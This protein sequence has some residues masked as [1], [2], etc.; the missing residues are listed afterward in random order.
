[1]LQIKIVCARIKINLPISGRWAVFWYLHGR[2]RRLIYHIRRADACEFKR[3]PIFP[4]LGKFILIL[5]HT[6]FIINI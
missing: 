6:V 5:V 1:M 2:Y 4:N 3:Q